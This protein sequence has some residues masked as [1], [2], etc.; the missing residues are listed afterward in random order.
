LHAATDF[1]EIDCLAIR[2]TKGTYRLMLAR[3]LHERTTVWQTRI[4]KKLFM[5]S[6]ATACQQLR[7]FNPRG[8]SAPDLHQWRVLSKIDD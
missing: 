7:R 5:G 1:L 8:L 2:Q 3:L 6:A 4:A